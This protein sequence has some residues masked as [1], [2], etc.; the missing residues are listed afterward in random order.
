MPKN[1]TAPNVPPGKCSSDHW[2][3]PIIFTTCNGLSKNQNP[4]AQPKINISN[5]DQI[6]KSNIILL[7]QLDSQHKREYDTSHCS[8]MRNHS[9]RRPWSYAVTSA[10]LQKPRTNEPRR[11]CRDRHTRCLENYPDPCRRIG[12]P[13]LD[14][15]PSV[16][17]ASPAMCW[18][19]FSFWPRL[20]RMNKNV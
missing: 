6:D 1:W 12:H 10:R 4:K 7:Y 18:W 11:V 19:G 13:V 9:A 16:T 2:L 8:T 17:P 5:R 3:L 14:R 20:N 15:H